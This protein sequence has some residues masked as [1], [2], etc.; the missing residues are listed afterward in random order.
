MSLC[1]MSRY[2]TRH[3][4]FVNAQTKAG[5]TPKMV[6]PSGSANVIMHKL[7]AIFLVL[8]S[9]QTAVAEERWIALGQKAQGKFS[10]DTASVIK[11]GNVRMNADIRQ[12]H[13]RIKWSDA[14]GGYDQLDSTLLF[15]CDQQFFGNGEDKFRLNGAL[16]K[17]LVYPD[18]QLH[19]VTA[20]VTV[21]AWET[22][23]EKTFD[24]TE[25][26]P[27]QSSRNKSTR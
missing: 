2:K 24:R 26:E 27:L 20:G 6:L 5:C 1:Y 3:G 13:V 17:H 7:A 8:A 12:A 16:V 19:K 9:Q 21:K 11:N 4:K 18:F 10:L 25:T 23:C 15:D 22:V 14:D